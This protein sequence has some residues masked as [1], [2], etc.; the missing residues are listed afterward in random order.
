MKLNYV[1]IFS[2]LT[3]NSGDKFSIVDTLAFQ[4]INA[5]ARTK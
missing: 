5:F 4:S 3:Y 1:T 2:I